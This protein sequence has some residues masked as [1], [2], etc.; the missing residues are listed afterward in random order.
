MILIEPPR[1]DAV[2]HGVMAFARRTEQRVP[3]APRV[4]KRD[5]SSVAN[6]N[7]YQRYSGI[8]FVDSN[9]GIGEQQWHETLAESSS[10]VLQL[11]CGRAEVPRYTDGRR[12]H[13]DRQSARELARR[14]P[15]VAECLYSDDEISSP[16]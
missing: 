10:L 14:R 1:F 9:I 2:D 6:V 3:P 8:V 16:S 4:E 15:V 5:S 13:T 7:G 11:R 12:N